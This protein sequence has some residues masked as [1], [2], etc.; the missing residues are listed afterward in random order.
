MEIVEG[1]F[2][3]AAA[4]FQHEQRYSDDGGEM[5]VVARHLHTP[6]PLSEPGR[7]AGAATRRRW[8]VLTVAWQSTRR[9]G[10]QQW[11]GTTRRLR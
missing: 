11:T 6:Q 9:R 1:F 8:F 2:R 3:D 5:A 7:V 10:N 4:R